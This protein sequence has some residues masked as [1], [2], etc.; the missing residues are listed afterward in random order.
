M[1]YIC[2][3]PTSGTICNGDSGSAMGSVRNGRWEVDGVV[4]FG[5]ECSTSPLSF[6]G[7][8]NVDLLK[9]WINFIM[10]NH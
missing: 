10:L 8:T 7:F 5:R 9:N 6:K 1:I 2:A 3:S 4:S